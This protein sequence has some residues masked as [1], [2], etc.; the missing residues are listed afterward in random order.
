MPAH[1]P[2]VLWTGRMRYNSRMF[3]QMTAIAMTSKFLSDNTTAPP[4]FLFY[5]AY[6]AQPTR[7]MVLD[8]FY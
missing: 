1:Y 3:T 8:D 6:T 7:K 4:Q 5:L 2:L